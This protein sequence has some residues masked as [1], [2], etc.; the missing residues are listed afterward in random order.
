MTRAKISQ[1]D[2]AA[3]NNT[4]INAVNVA[5]GCPPSGIN[6]AIREMGAMLKRMDNGTD[7]LTDPNITGSLDVDNI[8]INGN[9]IS[10][11][12][13]NGNVTVDPNG[14]GQINLSANVDV[15]GTVT[16]DGLTVDGNASLS[17]AGTGSRYLALL[18]ETNT[19]AGRYV[20]QAGG[21]SSGFGGGLVMYGHSHASNAG[22]VVA[23]ISSGSGGSFRVNNNG[24]D[25]GGNVLKAQENGDISFYADNGTTQGLFWDASTQRL[26]LGTTAPSNALTLNSAAGGTSGLRITSTEGS[27][28]RIRAESAT[29]TMLNVDSGESMLFGAGG[30][31]R[32]RI[33]SSGNVGIGTAS[34]A[35][36]LEISTTSPVIRSTHSISGDYLQLFHNGSGAYIDFSA[37]PLIIRG[38]S[39][40][41]RMRIDSSGNVGIGTSSPS[42]LLDVYSGSTNARIQ[43][44]TNNSSS[45]SQIEFRNTQAGTQIGMPANVN[46]MSFYTADTERMRIDSSGNLL[47]GTTSN[48]T[49]STIDTVATAGSINGVG[50]NCTTTAATGAMVFR[51]SNGQVGK[52]EVSGSATTYVTSSD[53]RL[54]E[55]VTADWD[56]T[57]RLKQL[58]P[59]RFNFIADADTTVD[60]FLAHEV[61][62]IVPEAISGT[63]DA[64]RDE[65]YTV[66]AGT[67]DIYTPAIEATYDEDGVELTAAIDEVIHSTDVERPEELAEGQQ[68]RETTPAVMG[69]RSVPDYQG[70]DQSKLTP[71]LTK[72]L[73]EAAEKIEQLEARIAA[74]EAN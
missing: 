54:K 24:I 23:G 6:N 9:T 68:W 48:A 67:G 32:M 62:D 41:E 16:A 27:G 19:Y 3:A 66:S 34:P 5:E 30:T 13:T 60:G 65:E 72:A 53:Y 14:T 7:H 15:T 73:I 18:N 64:M 8:N 44:Q 2:A 59:V 38:A 22:D 37:D 21:G 56:A 52:I 51:N 20:L 12:D 61:Q 71:L 31:E 25:G 35:T 1:L 17:G 47:V 42:E 10:S 39:N 36:P 57:T 46:A 63:K 49:T 58:N 50:V 4:D 55:N 29:T 43:I 74:L 26:G 11:T 28:F 45:V 69:T 40:A 33:D 70:I